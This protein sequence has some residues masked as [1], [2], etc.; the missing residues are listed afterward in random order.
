MSEFA[1]CNPD[2]AKA[3]AASGCVEGGRSVWLQ[4]QNSGLRNCVCVSLT[5]NHGNFRTYLWAKELLE[6]LP[7]DMEQMKYLKE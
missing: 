1:F 2:T 4:D 3:A 6:S 7:G 5:R